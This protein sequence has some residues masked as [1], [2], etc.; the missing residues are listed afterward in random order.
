ME[1][2]KIQFILLVHMLVL[3]SEAK[4]GIKDTFMPVGDTIVPIG[5]VRDRAVHGVVLKGHVRSQNDMWQSIQFRI[6]GD[7]HLEARETIDNV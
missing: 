4:G 7:T 5:L 1:E 2:M 6:R 3:A